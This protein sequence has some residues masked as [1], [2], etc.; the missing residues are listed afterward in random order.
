MLTFCPVPGV[1]AAC[2]AGSG[3]VTAAWF[4][5]AFAAS[6]ATLLAFDALPEALLALLP[7]APLGDAS[8]LGVVGRLA[9]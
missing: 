7:T 4:T 8:P 5:A 1:V 9:G 2:T 6:L 3:E